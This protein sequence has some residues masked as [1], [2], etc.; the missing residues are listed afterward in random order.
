MDVTQT[1]EATDLD[2]TPRTAPAKGS[3]AARRRRNRRW[4]IVGLLVV[5]AAVAGFL[6]SQLNGA[7]TYFY[8]VDQAVAKRADTG[9]RTFRIEGTVA[10]TPVKAT[11]PTGERLTFTLASNGVSTRCEYT[12]GEPSALF[13]KGEPVVL[14]GHWSGETFSS[15]LI[16]VKHDA[17]YDEKHPDRVT[18]TTNAP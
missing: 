18:T 8:T 5:L 13:K 11:T 14:E 9:G 3:L 2:L 12:G 6:I 1:P 4:G 7:T 10:D 16:M 17:T 15:S